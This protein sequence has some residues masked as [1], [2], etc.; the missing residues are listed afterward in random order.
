VFSGLRSRF[1]W[2]SSV[3][4]PLFPNVRAPPRLIPKLKSHRTGKCWIARTY[5]SCRFKKHDHLYWCWYGDA[6]C[7]VDVLIAVLVAVLVCWWRVDVLCV[8]VSMRWCVDVSMM[9]HRVWCV[10]VLKCWSVDVTCGKKVLSDALFEEPKLENL[11][12]SA[13]LQICI[14]EQFRHYIRISHGICLLGKLL[15]FVF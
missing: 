15:V 2:W 13:T 7:W 11:Q 10:D 1:W 9:C 8:D 14:L 6:M 5:C 4:A 12:K 3:D